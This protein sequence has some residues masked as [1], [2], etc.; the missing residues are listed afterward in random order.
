MGAREHRQLHQAAPAVPSGVGQEVPQHLKHARAVRADHR[1]AHPLVDVDVQPAGKVLGPNNGLVHELGHAGP[2]DEDG[3]EQRIDVGRLRRLLR[4][5]SEPAGFR[6]QMRDDLTPAYVVQFVPPT[7][8]RDDPPAHRGDGMHQFMCDQTDQIRPGT[9]EPLELFGPAL[10]G[11]ERVLQLC[12][13]A[14]FGEIRRANLPHQAAK[15]DHVEGHPEEVAGRDRVRENR[16]HE[17]VMDMAESGQ[18]QRRRQEHR[19]R[20]SVGERQGVAEGC[21]RDDRR[22]DQAQDEVARGKRQT[23]S[24][25]HHG[26]LRRP[27]QG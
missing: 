26:S 11:G 27:L 6:V 3:L 17:H 9:S 2:P 18:D 4:Q 14:A 7:L 21:G 19:G 5:V 15:H 25:Q 23:S 20:L 12:R 16:R 22:A 13:S 1:L 10:F 24:A 8:Q